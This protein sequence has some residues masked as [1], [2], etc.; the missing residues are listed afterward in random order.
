MG[1][2]DVYTHSTVNG[3]LMG[4]VDVYTHQDVYA[5]AILISNYSIMNICIC[6]DFGK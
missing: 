5:Y 3:L 4:F 2:G 6:P 1:C